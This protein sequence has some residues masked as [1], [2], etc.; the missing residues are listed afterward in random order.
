MKNLNLLMGLGLAVASSTAQAQTTIVNVGFEPDDAK[1]TTPWA[2]TPGGTYG[3]WVNRLE[4][5]EWSETSTDDP[6]SGKYC[7]EIANEEMVNGNTW[8]RG[9]KL[10]GLNLKDNTSYRVSFWVRAD[11]TCFDENGNEI[12]TRIKSSLSIG[13]EYF[14]NEII[15]PSGAGYNYQFNSGMTGDWRRISYVT[16]NTSKALLDA[17]AAE[18]YGTSDIT[19]PEELGGEVIGNGAQGFPE[20][21]YFLIINSYDP[22]T[23]SLDDIKIEEGVTVAGVSY[24]YDTFKI[25]FGY[26]TNIAELAVANDGSYNLPVS[27]IKITCGE[28]EIPVEFLEGHPDGHLYAFISADAADGIKSADIPNIKVSFTP[29]EDCE[30]VY[31]TDKRP[32]SDVE[33]EMK[34]LGFE[35]E[36]IAEDETIEE[37]SSA[38]SAPV[39]LST[40][41]DNNSFEL[42][43][44]EVKSVTFMF[45]KEV[46]DESASAT[47]MYNGKTTPLDNLSLNEDKMSITVDLPSLTDGTYTVTLSNVAN[48]YGFEAEVAKV[49]FSVGEDTDDSVSEDVY[50]PDWTNLANG[51]FPKGWVS[52]DNGTVHEY[53]FGSDGNIGN[54]NWGGNI[55][56]G[57]CRAMTGYSGDFK[58]GAMY[59]R[60]MNNANQLGELTYGAQ[61]TKYILE[62]GS[63]DP[64]MDPEVGLFLEPRNYHIT[65]KCAAWCQNNEPKPDAVEG[66]GFY[67]PNYKENVD[68]YWYTLESPIYNFELTDLKGNVYAEFHDIKA[69]PTV[70]RS[71]NI[72]V[73]NATENS[74]DFTVTE[75]GYYVLRFFS[76]QANAEFLMGGLRLITMPSKAAYY[77]G[78]LKVAMEDA[79]TVWAENGVEPY[80]G[81]TA[82]ALEK[83]LNAAQEGL[84]NHS[85]HTPAEIE[86]Q[87]ANIN[88]LVEALLARKAN[89]DMFN[90]NILTA[91]SA[92]D[93]L[94]GTKYIEMPGVPE[95]IAVVK[96][97]AETDPSTLDDETLAEVAPQ[98]KAAANKLS[99][100]RGTTDLLTWGIYKAQQ[101]AGNIDATITVDWTSATSDDRSIANAINSANK[102]RLYEIINAGKFAEY[103]LPYKTDGSFFED[104]SGV[105]DDED[106][107]LTGIEVTGSVQ[108]P[109]FYRVF[110][111]DGVPGWTIAQTT[112][113]KSINIAF[114]NNPSEENQIVDAQINIYGDADYDMSQNISNLVPGV[115]SVLIFT[116]TPLVTK[117]GDAWGDP[118]NEYTF[119]YNA[120]NEE[121]VWDKYIYANNGTEE[122][123]APFAGA[124]GLTPTYIHNV[125]VGADG[126]LNIGIHEHYVSGQAVAH[127]DNNPRDSW[128]GTSYVK[129][130]H[131]YL[132]APLEGYDYS[133]SS[134]TIDDI[135]ALIA[136]YLTEGTSVT[137]T[138]ITNL[139]NEY[140]S[141]E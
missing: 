22:A 136:D 3:D 80:N 37:M 85:F 20:N 101:T 133:K 9:F 116:R 118:D 21:S 67:D 108:N 87:I 14:D 97:Y 45:N 54:Y 64:E 11:E 43:K 19:L 119:Y 61:V 16:Y 103:A 99:N 139:I 52:D 2:L 68:K 60:C 41:P 17:K 81:A 6:H 50:T 137:I 12:N 113:D 120:Q 75:P 122:L 65:F 82:D 26:P 74:A 102:K 110:G 55:G 105:D 83:A 123:V 138:D 77:K 96:N 94:E 5:D 93:E 33:S 4:N 46:T 121:G 88:D 115:Y 44:K 125:T 32:S 71:Q 28:K 131:L 25:D 104:Y 38:W 91:T 29:S 107:S 53:C 124:S 40:T 42:D 89:V 78:E 141:Q 49:S 112:E 98:V 63:V 8:Q 66:D 34:V 76:T 39:L 27:C 106:R 100:L 7:M 90:D 128:T 30:I 135:T 48:I 73:T 18:R 51:T 69:I 114:N 13:R 132:T 130:V 31:N 109:K 35:N 70:H 57:G 62:D 23:Y 127:E 24:N 10:G 86:A 58:G 36:E 134:V 15:S 92:I 47:L 79:F 72:R 126:K 84:D 95:L 140:L 129:D 56:G 1:Y 117:M 59:W 111:N